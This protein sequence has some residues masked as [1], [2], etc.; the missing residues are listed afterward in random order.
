MMNLGH[1]RP[2]KSNI[3]FTWFPKKEL[4]IG[5]SCQSSKIQRHTKTPVGTF[6]LPD[7]PFTHIHID[8]VC[9]LPP[10]EGHNYLLTIIDRFSRWPEAIPIP[11]MRA[12]TI[13]RRYMDLSLRMSICNN[14]K[15]RIPVAFINVC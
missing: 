10:S 5:E 4:E 8:I 15:S 3:H 9:P 2:S 6:S 13:C 7:A 12:K 14:I 1:L 11:D